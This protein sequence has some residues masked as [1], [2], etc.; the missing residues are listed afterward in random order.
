MGLL[1]GVWAIVVKLTY[2]VSASQLS[3]V[4]LVVGAIARMVAVSTIFIAE[5]LPKLRLS[6]DAMF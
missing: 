3:A 6:R 2:L 1:P 4:V 5:W